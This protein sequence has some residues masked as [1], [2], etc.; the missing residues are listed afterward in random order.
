MSAKQ[1]QYLQQASQVREDFYQTFKGIF[2]GSCFNFQGL[3]KKAS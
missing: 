2:P 1:E 3:W